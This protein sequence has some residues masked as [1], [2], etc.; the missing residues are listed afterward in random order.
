MERRVSM[1]KRSRAFASGVGLVA[2]ASVIAACSCKLVIGGSG[3]ASGS[4]SLSS[5]TQGL[6]PGSGTPQKGGTLNMLG[7]GDVDYMGYEHQLLHDRLPGQ[8]PWIRGLY[9]YPAVPGKTTT[10]APDL[11][12]AAADDQQRRQD[13][14]DD[15]PHRRDVEHL[16]GPP[17][18]RG[19]RGARAQACVQPGAAV[20]WPARLRDADRRV[21]DLLQR[22]R[23]SAHTAA[24]IKSYIDRTRSP[25][26]RPPARPSPTTWPTRRPTSLTC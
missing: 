2:V 8:R 4:T 15:H 10:T 17:G 5:G 25:A 16:A 11:A 14:H 12:T 26:S 1:R 20:R 9:A 21:R 13:L 23:Q 18:H 24:A 19:R 6:N 3:T 7:V 22:L